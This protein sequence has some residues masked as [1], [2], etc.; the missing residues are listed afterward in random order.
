MIGNAMATRARG[1]DDIYFYQTGTQLFQS[2][3]WVRR[4]MN[5]H[6]PHVPD[7]AELW[8]RGSPGE[9]PEAAPCDP[10][11]PTLED[12]RTLPPLPEPPLD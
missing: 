10:T 3:R 5:G 8:I 11:M 6:A 9:C 7:F 2:F 4:T 1:H 12:L